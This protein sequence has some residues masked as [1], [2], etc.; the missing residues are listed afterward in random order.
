MTKDTIPHMLE[1]NAQ[2]LGDK[3]ALYD[4]RDGRWVPISWQEYSRLARQTARALLA[5]GYEK[6]DVVTILSNNRSE[7]VL[8]LVG[9]MMADGVG[10]GIYT[11]NS[12]EEVAYIVSHSES[13]VILVENEAQLAKVQQVWPDI[14]TLHYVVMTQGA[15]APT[16]D[17]RVMN[18]DD[19]L[20]K[21]DST[22]ASRVDEILDALEP[23]QVCDFIYTSGTTGPPKAVMLTHDNVAFTAQ[24]YQEALFLNSDTVALSY[25]PLSHIA[26]QMVTV[27]IMIA[28]G[29]TIYFVDDPLKLADYIREVRPTFFFGVPRVWERFYSVI[30]ARMNEATGLRARIVSWARGVGTQVT[31]LRNRGAEPSGWLAFQYRLADRLVFSKVKEAAGFDRIEVLGVGAAPTPIVIQEFFGSLDLRIHEVYGMSEG[32]SPTTGNLKAKTK[33]G[34]AGSTLPGIDVKIAEDGEI[35]LRGR[36]VFKGYYKNQQATDETL[37]NGWVHSGD[38]GAF[39]D[40]GFLTITGRK[41]DIIITSGGK[42]IAPKNLEAAMTALELVS[43]AVCVGEQQRYLVALLTLEPDAAKRFATTHG[44]A[45]ANLPIHPTLREHLETELKEKVNAHF[46]RVEHI[47]N[48]VVL[49]RDFSVETGELTPTFK[50]KRAVV[51]QMYADEIAGCYE[52]EQ[53][54]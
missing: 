11:S 6:G 8:G 29:Y 24:M 22:P 12:P 32:S 45:E 52:A 19:F 14:P 51:N 38:L 26:E 50:I 33:F 3:P 13:K 21:G 34:T 54:L 53:V 25:L 37:V 40:E 35:L 48:F 44:I 4:R 42:N 18:W 41:K 28:A 1:H 16:D 7:W 39:D 43:S 31:N 47:R 27:H 2:Q 17:D 20:A 5:L 36:N 49:L 15:D 46:A 30:S 10:T 23:D 9:A